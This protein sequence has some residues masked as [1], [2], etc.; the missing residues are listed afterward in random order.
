[1]KLKM[2]MLGLSITLILSCQIG[3]NA[4][5]PAGQTRGFSVT[6][7]MDTLTPAVSPTPSRTPTHT[8]TPTLDPLTATALFEEQST[9]IAA[10]TTA[11]DQEK[12]TI[13]TSTASAN[14]ALA[15]VNA[16]N[17]TATAR[18]EI[19]NLN[20]TEIAQY[21]SI[22]PNELI[23]HPNNHIGESVIVRGRVFYVINNTD[24]QIWLDGVS[25]E[26]VHIAM[27]NPYSDIF[28]NNFV[29]VYGIVAGEACG[30]NISGGNVC[31][32]QIVGVFY[33]KR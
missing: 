29:T 14:H 13:A 17:M 7:I 20:A 12:N 28:E 25:Y 33:E 15:T 19:A 6:S 4:P 3:Q 23:T 32:P 24:F 18:Q 10:N 26:P 11:T 22:D 30:T 8:S 27:V 1:M 31:Q 16:M 9:Q 21:T 2:L 5:G